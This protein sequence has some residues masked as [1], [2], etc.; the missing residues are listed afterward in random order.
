MPKVAT[1]DMP[2]LA[3]LDVPKV[4]YPYRRKENFKKEIE[5]ITAGL[6]DKMRMR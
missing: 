4:A 5:K 2:L 3:I 6:G 1:L